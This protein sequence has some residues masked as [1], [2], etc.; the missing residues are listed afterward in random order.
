MKFIL[1]MTECK[2]LFLARLEISSL[3]LLSKILSSFDVHCSLPTNERIK[4][5]VH[6]FCKGGLIL[7]QST[8]GRAVSVGLSTATL[9]LLRCWSRHFTIVSLYSCVSPVIIK[10]CFD[11]QCKATCHKDDRYSMKSLELS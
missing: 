5:R 11:S 3:F 8:Q 7:V 4:N 2:P 1:S 6:F 10:L 9:S